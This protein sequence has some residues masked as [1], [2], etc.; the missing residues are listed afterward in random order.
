MGTD[1]PKRAP[2]ARARRRPVPTHRKNTSHPHLDESITAVEQR[3]ATLQ[4]QAAREHGD[5]EPILAEAF[6]EL[7]IALEELQVA[8]EEL[9]QQNEELI[10][11]RQIAEVDRQRYQELFDFAPDAYLTTDVNGVIQEANQAAAAL[12]AVPRRHLL[13]KP[14]ILFVEPAEHPAF[15]K[16][17]TSL[18]QQVGVHTWEIRLQPHHREPLYAAVT[19]TVVHDTRGQPV[20]LRWLLRDI[21]ERRA[22]QER[23]QQ[24]EQALQHSR[25]QLRALATH[26]QN[27]Q[28]EERRRIAREIHDELAQ[29]LTALKIDLVWLSNQLRTADDRCRQRL[30]DMGVLLDGLV[31]SVRRIGTELRPGILDDLGLTA[32]IEWQLQEV[33]KRTGLSYELALPEEEIA[34]D[35]AHATAMFRIFQEALTNVVRHASARQVTVHLVPQPDALVLEIADDG[36]GI[37]PDQLVDRGSLGLLSMRERAHLLGGD[38]TIRGKSGEGTIVTLRMPYGEPPAEGGLV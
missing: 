5:G 11:T 32:A 31:S 15:Y 21:S 20:G 10:M 7:Q 37:T 14:L 27:Q 3:L 9:R 13:G 6:Q 33:Y 1:H 29:A 4:K 16:R 19:T 38:V 25:E 30:Q 26:L 22:A 23:A 12:L 24:A 34:V 2:K 36:K 8:D 18:L 28:E 17:L 35:Q